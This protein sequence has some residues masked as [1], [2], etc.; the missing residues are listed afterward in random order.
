M[1]NNYVGNT[2]YQHYADFGWVFFE[3]F[4]FQQFWVFLLKLG[5]IPF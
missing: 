2:W 4:I 1:Y 3:S 5:D